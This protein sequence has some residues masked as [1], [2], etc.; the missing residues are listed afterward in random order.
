MEG[1]IGSQ[2]VCFL[3]G[4]VVAEPSEILKVSGKNKYSSNLV[5]LTLLG[6]LIGSFQTDKIL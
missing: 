4:E 1:K 3:R 5:V 6:D 2:L